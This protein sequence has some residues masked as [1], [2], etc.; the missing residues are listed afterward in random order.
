[1]TFNVGKGLHS[2]NL[3]KN[4]RTPLRQAFY[5][6]AKTQKYFK[7]KEVSEDKIQVTLNK[8]KL[9]KANE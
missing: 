4:G 1:M 6:I 5:K 3:D 9:W 2:N 8:T 7:M